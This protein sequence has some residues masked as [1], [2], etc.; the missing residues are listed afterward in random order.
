[1]KNDAFANFFKIL[2]E[3]RELRADIEA[4]IDAGTAPHLLVPI[5][6]E[7]A[8]TAKL[9]LSSRLIL[10][11]TG[12]QRRGDP[13]FRHQPLDD[14]LHNEFE[15]AIETILRRVLGTQDRQWTDD[16]EMLSLLSNLAF[17]QLFHAF[18]DASNS[19]M[20]LRHLWPLLI[21]NA[22]FFRATPD[23]LREFIDWCI[24]TIKDAYARNPSV[25]TS[26]VVGANREIEPLFKDC[27]PEQILDLI[28]W[29]VAMPDYGSWLLDEGFVP[30][31][32][33]TLKS[34][35]TQEQIWREVV[36]R[37]CVNTNAVALYLEALCDV[38]A[39]PPES[40]GGYL[41]SN[42]THRPPRDSQWWN[43]AVVAG[44]AIRHSVAVASAVEFLNYL[45]NP[46][47]S[48]GAWLRG[49]EV[50]GEPAALHFGDELVARIEREQNDQ[51]LM[52][53]VYTIGAMPKFGAKH[54][55]LLRRKRFRSKWGIVPLLRDY[56]T[57]TAMN[58]VIQVIQQSQKQQ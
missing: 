21:D 4:R 34:E 27:T 14:A 44:L 15:S 19:W 41:H 42:M 11:K 8:K 54:I 39:R 24:S 52:H 55:S 30:A 47:E 10:G 7:V 31:L 36:L 1:M 33:T 9:S 32:A 26:D 50:A 51:S 6:K 13:P 17:P 35:S 22:Y 2:M 3:T 28:N 12:V 16:L 57:S 58:E 18:Q 5:A 40:A 38:N 25:S 43:C 53:Y 45:I 46:I 20:Q 29:L 56:T 49:L 23:A 48:V 37:D